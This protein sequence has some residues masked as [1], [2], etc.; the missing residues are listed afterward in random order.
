MI[1]TAWYW[2]WLIAMAATDAW[3][4][5]SITRKARLAQHHILA[6]VNAIAASYK[7]FVRDLERIE[8]WAIDTLAEVQLPTPRG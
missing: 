8:Q 7:A 4:L 3:R 2:F 6:E 5:A 1:V